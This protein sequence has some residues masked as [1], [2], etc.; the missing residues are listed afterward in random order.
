MRG[1]AR[2]T[3]PMTLCT[4]NPLAY[5]REV[6]LADEAA[7]VSLGQQL[8]QRLSAPQVI[9]LQGELG[10]GK[11]TFSRGFLQG[12]GHVGS[13]KSPTYTLVEPYEHLTAGPVF[14][15]DL[16]RLGDPGELEYLGLEDYLSAEGILLIEWPERAAQQL[17]QPDLEITLA[18]SMPA[19]P[20]ATPA[21]T[22]AVPGR[23]ATVRARSESALEGLGGA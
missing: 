8:A 21:T 22:T 18:L 7:T 11:T 6:N 17:P 15:L 20:V 23:I 14:H 3:A 9:Y 2:Y 5:Q 1:L 19:M 10:A 13:V 16:Y 4:Q 12:R